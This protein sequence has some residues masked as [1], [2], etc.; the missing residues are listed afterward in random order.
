MLAWLREHGPH[1]QA[2]VCE[3]FGIS[4]TKASEMLRYGRERGDL[5]ITGK[6]ER[7]KLLIGVV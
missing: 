7:N 6:S 3:Q 4:S 2:Q 5:Q 1:T